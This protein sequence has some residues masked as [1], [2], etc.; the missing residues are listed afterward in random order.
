M[1]KVSSHKTKALDPWSFT[2]INNKAAFPA[3][4]SR[5]GNKSNRAADQRFEHL[6]LLSPATS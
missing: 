3:N 5:Q 4:P 1:T 6:F 2:L